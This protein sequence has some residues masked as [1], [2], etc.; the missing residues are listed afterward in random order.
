MV[1]RGAVVADPST[2]RGA[3]VA[4]PSTARGAIAADRTHPAEPH[5]DA[6]PAPRQCARPS[7]RGGLPRICSAGG[8]GLP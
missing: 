1:V 7:N 3:V 4:D 6:A 5:K 8:A 2:A